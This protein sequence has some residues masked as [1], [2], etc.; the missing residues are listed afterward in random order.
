MLHIPDFRSAERTFQLMEQVSGR[1]GRH[2]RPGEVLLQSYT[3]DHYS[4]QL[5]KTHDF[6]TF[7]QTEMIQRKVGEYPPYRFMALVTIS[8]PDLPNVIEKSQKITDFLKRTLSQE[9][10]IL[11]PVVSPIARIKDRYR[12]QC[13]IK[14]K[15]EPKLIEALQQILQHYM[16]DTTQG[17]LQ[18]S[19]DMHPYFFM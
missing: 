19:L 18:I 6:E 1:A 13:M 3:P 5:V 2:E 8:D 12:Y 17:Q 16:R 14:Y 15:N 4:I 10:V 7:Y 9:T 11:G